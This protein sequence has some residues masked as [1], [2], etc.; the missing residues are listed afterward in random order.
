[1]MKYDVIILA[2]PELRSNL[3]C[4]VELSYFKWACK[5]MHMFCKGTE[6]VLTAINASRLR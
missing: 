6:N 4:F 1:M 2:E 3:L 5:Y